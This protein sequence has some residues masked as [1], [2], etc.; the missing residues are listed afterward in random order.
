MLLLFILLLLT[1]YIV[2]R[3]LSEYHWTHKYFVLR[4]ED[5]LAFLLR[6]EEV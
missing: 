4:E 1:G 2:K 6:K 3:S 5:S